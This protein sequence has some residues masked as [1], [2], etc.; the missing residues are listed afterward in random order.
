MGPPLAAAVKP[1]CVDLDGTVT[2]GDALWE[3]TLQLA[4]THPAILLQMPGWLVRGKAFFK[5]QMA[6]Q[7]MI[8]PGPESFHGE[9]VDWLRGEAA[10]GRRIHLVTGAHRPAAEAAAAYCDCFAEISASGSTT[11]LTGENKARLLVNRYG[12]RGYDYVGNSAADLPAW[13]SSD[14]AYAV[15][16][17][18]SLLPRLRKTH[19]AAVVRLPLPRLA[20]SAWKTLRPQQLVKN[21]LL[22]LALVLAHHTSDLRA[23]GHATLGFV[24]FS[25]AAAFGYCV[26]DLLDLA[27]DR[28]DVRKSK[29]PLA[30]GEVSIPAGLAL[31]LGFFALATAV[32]FCLPP[33]FRI[34]FFAYVAASPL[35]SL[36]LKRLI[37]ADVLALTG[38]YVLRILAGGLATGIAVSQWLLTFSLF[39]FLSLS[40]VKRFGELLLWKGRLDD[41]ECLPGRGYQPRDLETVRALGASSAYVSVLVFILYVNTPGTQILYPFPELL[42]CIGVLLAF[43]LNRLWMLAGRGCV[44]GDP[45]P[46]IVR[47]PVSWAVAAGA[48]ALALAAALLR[49]TA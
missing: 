4:R 44:P 29:R 1:L 36:V 33:V 23:I 39:L 32:A 12:S 13:R 46:F 9:I 5:D 22:F 19:P 25:L 49:H 20:Y 43:W 34:A 48:A 47:D 24:A 28:Q 8:A 15:R 26:N 31:G 11:N 18:P 27:A 17:R 7:P 35:Y 14:V 45:I 2:K 21:L 40:L 10:A 3:Q 6:R 38:L 30:A 41:D 16:V 42:W 37:G